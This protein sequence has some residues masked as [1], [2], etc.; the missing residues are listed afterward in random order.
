MA[1]VKFRRIALHPWV[2]HM[3]VHR[4]LIAFSRGDETAESRRRMAAILKIL[5]DRLDPDDAVWDSPYARISRTEARAR[6]ERNDEILCE[7]L[8]DEVKARHTQPKIDGSKVVHGWRPLP[9]PFARWSCDFPEADVR[10]IENAIEAFA[11]KQD[12]THEFD[13]GIVDA[14]DEIKAAKVIEVDTE[15]ST[16]NK[17]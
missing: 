10:V 12:V 4:A 6:Q 17:A 3:I 14:L 1:V 15:R 2:W 8:G 11:K 7:C 16:G 5:N 9:D 13:Q